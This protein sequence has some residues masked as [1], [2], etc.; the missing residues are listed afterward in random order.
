[1]RR[2]MPFLVSGAVALSYGPAYADVRNELFK[3]LPE[4]GA[5]YELFG[6]SVAISGFSAIVGAPFDDDNGDESGSAYLFDLA[7]AT[8]SDLPSP[9]LEAT[10]QQPRPTRLADTVGG[11]ADRTDW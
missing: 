10:A 7:R 5:A 1:M 4:D 6:T 11:S 9:S 3:L 8:V 2:V